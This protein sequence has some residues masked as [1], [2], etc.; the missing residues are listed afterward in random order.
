MSLVT[1]LA[2]SCLLLLADQPSTGQEKPVPQEKTAAKTGAQE[3]ARKKKPQEPNR[4]YP[5]LD[6]EVIYENKAAKVTLAG[7]FT[8]PKEG[9]PFAA[10]LLITGS[11]KQDRDET[12][13][14][15]K[16]FLVLADYLTRKGIA[17]LR[18]DDRGAGKSS[19][20]FAASTSADFA[21]DVEAGIAYLKSRPDVDPKRIGLIGHSEGGLIAP[22]VAARNADVA[23]IVLLGGQ[24]LT[25]EEVMVLQGQ[26]LMKIQGAT[27]TQL[28][29]QKRVQEK[30]FAIVKAEADPAE[31]E[32][33]L[34]QT[35]E[36]EIEPLKGKDQP[37]SDAVKQGIAAQLRMLKGP[38]LRFFLTYDPRVALRKV[39]CPV[40]AM[41]GDKDAQVLPK[42]NLRE[43]EMALK[44]GGNSDFTIKELP[45]MNH[46]FQV[47][48]TGDV[49]EYATI[50]ETI[51]PLALELIGSW[52]VAHTQKK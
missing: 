9:S 44:A 7:T 33:K 45:G 20:D 6:E 34:R 47:C 3:S 21:T 26:K 16:P 46:L 30:L 12:M 31:R 41:V 5:Y 28:A 48:K 49:M 15:H 35:L 32:K 8:R 27:E 52:I 51:S 17:V 36:A 50:E 1:M 29:T 19:G 25:G 38:W 43:I 23:Y 4:P 14:G 24:G 11:G 39:R 13:M 37:M 10:V 2:A 42:E 18:V 22:M 40:L